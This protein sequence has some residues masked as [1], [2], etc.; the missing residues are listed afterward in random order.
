[1]PKIWVDFVLMLGVGV[2]LYLFV[3]GF[4]IFRKYL[5]I[6]DTPESHIRGLAMGLVKVHG[7][8]IGDETLTSPVSH[9]P[10]FFYKVDVDKWKNDR[11]L[12]GSLGGGRWSHYWTD[13]RGVNFYLV[14]TTGKVLIDPRGAEYDLARRRVREI[15]RTGGLLDLFVSKP[16][17]PIGSEPTDADLAAYV[18]T[19]GA[20]ASSSDSSPEALTEASGDGEGDSELSLPGSIISQPA[21]T[22]GRTPDRNSRLRLT[23][24]YIAPGELY[25]VT[26]TCVENPA[27]QDESDLNLIRKG[28]NEPTFLISWRS[29]PEIESALRTKAALFIFGGAALAIYCLYHLIVLAGSG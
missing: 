8:T 18:T 25:D 16:T 9:T 15:G 13:I 29:E 7:S 26:G 11:G 5:V 21:W 10:C 20:S 4:R 19:F 1:M 6:A 27:A 23:E 14:D 22:L 2:G 28:K 24:Y 12:R 3:N 17:E